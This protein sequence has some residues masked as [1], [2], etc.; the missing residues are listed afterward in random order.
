MKILLVL[1][2]RIPTSNYD[3]A[4]RVLWWQARQLTQMGHE[5]VVLVK[6]GSVCDF[7]PVLVL[8]EKKA[9]AGQV[10]EDVDVVHFFLL[11]QQ[12][13]SPGFPNPT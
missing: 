1:N 6:P 10:P 4:E 2:S 3:D 12:K 13:S 5:P 8:D 7:A 9:L 11:A